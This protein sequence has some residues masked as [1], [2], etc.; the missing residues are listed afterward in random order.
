M[1]HSH[2]RSNVASI[3]SGGG[4][5]CALLTN[6]SL[7][8]WGANPGGQVCLSLTSLAT[9]LP[10]FYPSVSSILA[11]LCVSS[12]LLPSSCCRGISQSVSAPGM[13]NS[14]PDDSRTLC[15]FLLGLLV[16]LPPGVPSQ[17]GANSTYPAIP[18]PAIVMNSV[19]SVSAGLNHTCAVSS[20]H[21]V[22]CWGDN[23][24]GT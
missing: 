2:L 16:S 1:F 15:V 6:G 17:I 22:Y 20:S 14:P 9:L 23:E 12:A 3:S 19:A 21:G 8:C 10:L 4:H 11:C 5:L 24:Y 7:A 13:S 18:S